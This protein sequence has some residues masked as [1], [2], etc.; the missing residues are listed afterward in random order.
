MT[1]R[2]SSGDD[3]SPRPA[4]KSAH[5]SPRQYPRDFSVPTI[6][7]AMLRALSTTG[8]LRAG[9]GGMSDRALVI[10]A[11]ILVR[12]ILHDTTNPRLSIPEEGGHFSSARSQNRDDGG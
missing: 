1:I 5:T 8:T 10:D 11:H 12:S 9:R 4:R 6:R 3:S 2:I 7:V